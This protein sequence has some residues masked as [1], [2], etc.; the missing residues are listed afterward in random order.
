MNNLP[1]EWIN[2]ILEILSIYPT[3]K[4]ELAKWVAWLNRLDKEE[5]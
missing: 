4:Q 1:E 5:K 2:A 3:S